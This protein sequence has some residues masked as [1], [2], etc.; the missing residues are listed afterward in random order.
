VT[1]VSKNPTHAEEL[2]RSQL[3]LRAGVAAVAFA[4][5]GTRSPY[6][7]AG[8]LK[9]RHR[10]LKGSLSI[11]Q[12]SHFVPRYD[13]WFGTWAKGW[14]EKNDVQVEVDHESY[15]QLPALAATEVKRQRG[16]DIFGFLSPPAR[17]EDQVINHA[18][19]VSQIEAEVGPY[20]ELGMRS[21]YNPKTKKY[22]GVSDY[23]V[24]APVIWRHD[25]WNDIGESPATWDHVRAAAP[26]LKALGHPVG[27]GQGNDLDSNV[28]L[29]SL[30]MCF[31]AFL[32]D[33]S[34]T[35]TIDGKNTVE[36]VQFMADLH[37][38]GGESSVFGWNEASNNQFVLGGRGSLIVNAIS[39]IRR[40]EDLGMP[41]ARELWIWP[42]PHGPRGRLGVGQYTSV[43]SVWKFAKNKDVAEQFLADL[44]VNSGQ[45]TPESKL[46]NFP[47]F[48]GAYPLKQIYRAA[49]ADT[50]QPR[51]KYSILTTVASKYTRNA[52]YP[53]T[54]NAAVQ[55]VLDTF[56]IP[57]MFARVS[58]G[59][60]SAGD[61][62]RATASEMKRIWAKWRAA[63][64]L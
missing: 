4:A 18:A 13:A 12:W 44:C 64:K 45:A 31:G 7:F 61:S 50:H 20:G 53:G 32:Q 2:T 59:T 33:E 26:A 37:A 42:V 30:L 6:A 60:M 24:P 57:Q 22:V 15:T 48:P 36:A 38:S 35:L 1:T 34:N 55:E 62:V 3:L 17:Y 8:P 52:G 56:L 28:A 58:Q 47:S 21:T 19:I 11:V 25:L 49:A 5:A 23:F 41:L 9:Y 46:F 29:L 40:A 39:A 63:G 54:S 51:G 10:L 14:G 43:Y 16:H 27:I